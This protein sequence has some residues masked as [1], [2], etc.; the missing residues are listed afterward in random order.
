MVNNKQESG[1]SA[2]SDPNPRENTSVS[3]DGL[4]SSRIIIFPR[5]TL[6]IK[7][8]FLIFYCLQNNYYW[9]ITKK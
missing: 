8:Y 9:L 7:V 4:L 1:K 2:V 5:K 6:S 3:L